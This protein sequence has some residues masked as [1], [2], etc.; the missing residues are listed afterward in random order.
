M[1]YEKEIEMLELE[2][3][4]GSGFFWQVR[5]GC[6]DADEFNRALKKVSAVSIAQDADVPFRLVSLLWFI[7]LFMEWQV[8]R[9]GRNGGD[10]AAY[11]MAVSTMTGE[12]MRLL[13]VP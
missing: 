2:W 13:G 5:Q 11:E 9:V 6:F 4:A 3:E 1:S 10:K 8:E 12:V 7:P